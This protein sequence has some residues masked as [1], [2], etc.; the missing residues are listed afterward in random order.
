MNADLKTGR[1]H[2]I[3]VHLQHLGFPIV[4]DVKYGDFEHN[5]QLLK[6]GFKRMFL[7]A[8]SLEFVHPIT[9]ANIY[10]EAKL[11]STLQSF[12]DSLSTRS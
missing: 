6:I 12:V 7:H 4:G 5:K 2:Q 8:A 10:L 11:P 9:N 1:T 3:R